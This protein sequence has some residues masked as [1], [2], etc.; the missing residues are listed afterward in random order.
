MMQRTPRVVLTLRHSWH[1]LHGLHSTCACG[2]L[3]THLWPACIR[4]AVHA[5]VACHSERYT[6]RCHLLQVMHS[7]RVLLAPLRFGAGLKGKVVDAWAHGLPVCTTPIGAE[8]MHDASSGGSEGAAPEHG[9]AVRSLCFDTACA[10][11]VEHDSTRPG[12]KDRRGSVL[13]PDMRAALATG[14]MLRICLT[15]C[16]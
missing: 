15:R 12:R 10:C 5:S 13:V 6:R 7:Y 2:V 1:H 4:R 14:L 11:A 3:L 8:G 16:V 9:E